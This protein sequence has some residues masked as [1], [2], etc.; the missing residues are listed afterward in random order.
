M[1]QAGLGG[2]SVEWED[3]FLTPDRSV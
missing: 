3:L 2:Q 1:G